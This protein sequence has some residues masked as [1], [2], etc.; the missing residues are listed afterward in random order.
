MFGL[1]VAAACLWRGL[2]TDETTQVAAELEAALAG[3]DLNVIPAG[4]ARDALDAAI[5]TV[6]LRTRGG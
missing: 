6:L 2:T 1:I 4:D 5:S 3:Q